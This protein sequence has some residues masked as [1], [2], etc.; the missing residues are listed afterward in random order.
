[1]DFIVSTNFS[2]LELWKEHMLL[3]MNINQMLYYFVL[4]TVVLLASL[5]SNIKDFVGVSIFFISSLSFVSFHC[6]F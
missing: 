2:E 1:M 5:K 6:F 3:V 4:L